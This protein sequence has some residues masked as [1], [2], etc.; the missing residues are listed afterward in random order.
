MS[1]DEMAWKLCR[2]DLKQQMS[3]AKQV[4]HKLKLEFFHPSNIEY[5][6]LPNFLLKD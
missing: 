1:W 2:I 6:Q 3:K 4:A 5:S